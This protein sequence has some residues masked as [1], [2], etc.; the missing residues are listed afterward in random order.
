MEP[1]FNDDEPLWRPCPS[2]GGMDT[3]TAAGDCETCKGRGGD[4]DDE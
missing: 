2:C 1:L 3:Y 4:P